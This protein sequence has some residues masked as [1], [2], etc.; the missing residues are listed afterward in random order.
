MKK[1]IFHNDYVSIAD[2]QLPKRERRGV[3]L[4]QTFERMGA[5]KT[6]NPFVLWTVKLG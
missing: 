4:Q 2:L 3:Q 1:S 5:R 6:C